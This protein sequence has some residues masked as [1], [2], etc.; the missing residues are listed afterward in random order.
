MSDFAGLDALPLTPPF[1][2]NFSRFGSMATV[3]A[4]DGAAN[5]ISATYT[6]GNQARYYPM[7]LPWPYLV[8]RVFW[9]NGSSVTGNRCFA[10]YTRDYK[11]IYTTGSVA[12]SG[13]TALQ[14]VTPTPFLLQPGDYY[15]GF[16]NSG[17]TNTVWGKTVSA[18]SQRYA[19][20]LQQAVGATALPDPM[21]PAAATVASINIC[22]VT[23]T[24]SGF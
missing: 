24:D 9:A 21:V 3:R 1:L 23:W 18:E 15:F 20:I 16:N 4:V 11:Q 6:T 10:I 19:G 5:P 13:G 8:N 22:G 7:S 2:S 12:A 14:Y 17:T